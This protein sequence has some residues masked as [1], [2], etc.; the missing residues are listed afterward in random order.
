M[1]EAAPALDLQAYPEGV[2]RVP[3]ELALACSTSAFVS[4]INTRRA[5]GD[6]PS[7]DCVVFA[8]GKRFFAL[9]D[10]AGPKRPQLLF[11]LDLWT[12]EERDAPRAVFGQRGVARG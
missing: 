12:W 1:A 10:F 5:N 11:P 2:W 8:R 4:L 9:V 3:L 6:V 7:A